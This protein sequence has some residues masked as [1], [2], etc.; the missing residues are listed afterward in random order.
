MK[1]IIFLLSL[2]S[3]CITTHAQGNFINNTTCPLEYQIVCFNVSGAPTT[4]TPTPSGVWIPVGA[5]SSKPLPTTPC[6]APS[7]PGYIVRYAPSTG[8]SATNVTIKHDMAIC[9]SYPPNSLLPPCP[10][11]NSGNPIVVFANG[12]NVFA[13][14]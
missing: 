13:N 9:N 14:P 3:M 10:T 6:T 8:C 7:E 1:Q 11:C 4:C 2:L 5:S 12:N